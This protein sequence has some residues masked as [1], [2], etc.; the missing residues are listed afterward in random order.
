M[1]DPRFEGSGEVGCFLFRELSFGIGFGMPDHTVLT[2]APA[3]FRQR[4]LTAR[5]PPPKDF[6]VVGLGSSAGGLDAC[7]KLVTALPAD[8]GMAFVLVQHLDPTHK[9]MMVDLLA[10]HTT[11]TVLEAVDGMAI[12]PDHLYI[13]APGTYLSVAQ[14]ALRVSKPLAKHGARLPFD[15]LLHSLAE[16]FGSRAVCVILSGTGSDGC[17][18]LSAV[19]ESSGLVI[20]QDPREAGYDGMPRSAIATCTVDLVMPVAMIPDALATYARRLALARSADGA[21]N[22]D[23]ETDW[24]PGII[25]LL[26]TK[27]AHDF[28]LYKQGTLQRRIER[29]MALAAIETGSMELYL[30][31]SAERS[32]GTRSAGQGSADQR[33][34][35]FSRPQ[36]F[37]FLAE[38]RII[39]RT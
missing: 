22:P 3:R 15:F 6:L 36:G 39:S 5:V 27:T 8:C 34:E 37:R 4:A 23:L 2:T 17:L 33:H 30:D 25:E 19:K 20:A 18:G 12:E 29:R 31:A 24:L 21:R 28:T 26:R 16:E 38:R 10:G 14:G 9:S 13:I 1:I 7:R 11:M 32:Q 35:F